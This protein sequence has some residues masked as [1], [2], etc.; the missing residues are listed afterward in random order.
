M[1]TPTTA[2]HFAE[3]CS[4]ERMV[5]QAP[6]AMSRTSSASG[7]L[8]RNIRTATGVS[9][10]TRPL[11]RPAAAPK[12]RFTVAWTTPTVATPMSTSGRR[13]AKELRP[14]TRTLRAMTHS[15][16]GGLSTVMELPASEEPNRNASQLSLPACTAAE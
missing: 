8:K 1:K 4:M 9:A 3:P 14:R 2:N 10:S 12:C 7:L 16:A 15:A 13:I 6:S 11:R 5:A